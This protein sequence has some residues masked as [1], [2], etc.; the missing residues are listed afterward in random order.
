MIRLQSENREKPSHGDGIV[1][2]CDNYRPDLLGVWSSMQISLI[3]R[4]AAHRVMFLL[5]SCC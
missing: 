2:L 5:V 3:M 4:S 1:A